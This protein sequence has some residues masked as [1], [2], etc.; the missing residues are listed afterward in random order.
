MKAFLMFPDRDFDPEQELVVLTLPFLPRGVSPFDPW[1]LLPWSA[2]A[3]EQDLELETL[4]TGMAGNDKFLFEVARNAVLSAVEQDRETVLY[5]QDILRDCLANPDPVRQIYDLTIS[6]AEAAHKK[7]GLSSTS[8]SAILDR[9]RNVL[10]TYVKA[11]KQLRAIADAQAGSLKSDG[12]SRFLSMLQAELSDAY[13]AEIDEHLH[14]LQFRH[15]VLVSAG[16]GPGNRGTGYVLRKPE[17]DMHGWFRRLF[18]SSPDGYT[19]NIAPR[20]EAGGR[21][22]GQ[23]RDRGLSLVAN[24]LAHSADHIKNFFRMLRI[25]LGFYIGCMNLAGRLDALHEPICFPQPKPP[26][27]RVF[28]CTGLYD[29]ALALSQKASVTGNDIDAGA[30]DLIVVTGANRGGKSTFLRSFGQAHLMMQAGMFVAAERLSADMARGIFTHFKR[31]EDTSMQSGKLDEE[32]ARMSAIIDHLRPE[33]LVLFNESFAATTEREG[34]EIARQITCALGAKRIKM[35]HV[36]HLYD[37]SGGLHAQPEGR[38]FL[39]AN[40]AA[41]EG[42]NYRL[43]EGAPLSTSYGEDLYRKM[44]RAPEEARPTADRSDAVE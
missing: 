6:T 16:L 4:F 15:G 3:L 8:A 10:G 43:S 13:F 38:Y 5:R 2:P 26:K 25:E 34:S 21:E 19:L 37:F 14:R 41:G 12:F 31:E 1:G 39:R 30:S 20:D 11:L 42:S 18:D 24:A 17:N 23:L 22:L 9:S 29:V 36:T 40:R 28:S 27:Q 35:V 32:L 33:S 44:F 7:I